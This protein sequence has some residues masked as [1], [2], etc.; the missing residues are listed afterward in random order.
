MVNNNTKH[1]FTSI[2]NS[3]SSM[4]DDSDADKNYEPFHKELCNNNSPDCI[5]ASNDSSGNLLTL[6]THIYLN[7]IIISNLD[8]LTKNNQ[9]ITTNSSQNFD[10]VK[11]IQDKVVN[12][13]VSRKLLFSKEDCR[14]RSFDEVSCR[15]SPGNVKQL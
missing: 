12:V 3:S 10:S 1:I 4:F 13:R 8:S 15:Y 14:K 2:A 7:N 11:N 9:V 6:Y 5:E